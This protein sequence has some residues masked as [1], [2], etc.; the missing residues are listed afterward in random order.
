MYNF[1][2]LHTTEK[3]NK[4]TAKETLKWDD[5]KISNPKR[6]ILGNCHIIKGKFPLIISK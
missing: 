2:E 1:V 6:P 4:E 5:T 3:S